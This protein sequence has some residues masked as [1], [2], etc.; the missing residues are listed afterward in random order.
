MNWLD[1]G[2]EFQALFVKLSTFQALL[3]RVDQLEA[4]VQNL[5]T[6]QSASAQAIDTIENTQ[7]SIWSFTQNALQ[8]IAALGG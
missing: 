8:R 3:A 7:D 6:N 5:D 4:Q 1:N 2:S